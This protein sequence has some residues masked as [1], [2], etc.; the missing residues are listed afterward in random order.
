[1]GQVFNIG[2]GSRCSVNEVLATLEEVL[3]RPIRRDRRPP[4]PGDVSH[5]WAD[6]RRA[7][8]ILGFAPRVS[9][10]E[11]LAHEVVWLREQIGSR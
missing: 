2:G 5:T 3:G 1:V 6:T 7:R 9:L 10:R 4:Q 11:G 8:D